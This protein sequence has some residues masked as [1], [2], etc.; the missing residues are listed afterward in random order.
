MPSGPWVTRKFFGQDVIRCPF[1][2]GELEYDLGHECWP[3]SLEDRDLSQSLP[4]EE[5]K[6]SS[7]F[8]EFIKHWFHT[9][10]CA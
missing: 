3:F 7:C 2:L 1:R 4:Y 9:K 10:N 8:S 5:F 6:R